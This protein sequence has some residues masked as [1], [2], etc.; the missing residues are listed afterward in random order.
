MWNTIS[1]ADWLQSVLEDKERVAARTSSD[2]LQSDVEE[3][4][5]IEWLASSFSFKE[6]DFVSPL[7]SFM[8]CWYD[9]ETS[10]PIVVGEKGMLSLLSLFSEIM[11]FCNWFALYFSASCIFI[12][13]VI[14]HFFELFIE[15]FLKFIKHL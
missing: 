6:R 13:N 5:T 2:W 10:E 7:L 12:K 15:F 14:M 3:V 9:L 1:S 4:E 11:F 8:S